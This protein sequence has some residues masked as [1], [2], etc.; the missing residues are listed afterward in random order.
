MF[1]LGTYLAT[2]DAAS[3]KRFG[4]YFTDS[5]DDRNTMR[6]V[7]NGF[8]K[9]AAKIPEPWVIAAFPVELETVS[10]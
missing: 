4:P 1:Q 8:N 5:E 9:K 7:I 10:S 6:K 3:V 2:D